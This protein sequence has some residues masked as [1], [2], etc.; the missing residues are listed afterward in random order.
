MKNIIIFLI[1]LLLLMI[2][3]NKENSTTET[4]Q[5]DIVEPLTIVVALDLSDRIVSEETRQRDIENILLAFDGFEERVK[6]LHYVKSE[7][8]FMLTLVRQTSTPAEVK[9]LCDTLSIDLAAYNMRQKREAMERFKNEL[10]NKVRRIYELA[11]QQSLYSGADIYQ[12]LE[13]QLPACLEMANG[14]VTLLLMTDG[15]IE[16]EP[17]NENVQNNDRCNTMNSKTM[18]S[19][20]KDD[21]FKQNSDILLVPEDLAQ[22]KDLDR[23]RICVVGIQPKN[24][25]IYEMEMVKNIWLTWLGKM[26][27]DN[28]L[29]DYDQPAIVTKKLLINALHHS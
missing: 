19:L 26:N 23:L 12:Y 16:L 20:R 10:P 7:D 13:R 4:K 6:N 24:T 28:R 15:Y 21:T 27:I 9:T 3:C 1:T 17:A 11:N 2:S 22:R 8:R 14:K 29:I 18:H 5:A 25:Y